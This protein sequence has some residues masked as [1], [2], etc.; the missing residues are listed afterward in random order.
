MLR[1]RDFTPQVKQQSSF[2]GIIQKTSTLDEVVAEA[3]SWIEESRVSVVNIETLI[4]PWSGNNNQAIG[5][6]FRVG[7]AMQMLQTVRVWYRAT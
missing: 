3:N 5:P 6:Y 4:L 7:E 2:L 1:Y